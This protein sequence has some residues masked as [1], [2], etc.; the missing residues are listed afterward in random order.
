MVGVQE[1]NG[2][3]EGGEFNWKSFRFKLELVFV[4]GAV[5]NTM[6]PSHHDISSG[7]RFDF[8][9]GPQPLGSRKSFAGPQ[10]TN[11]YGSGNELLGSRKSMDWAQAANGWCPGMQCMVSRRP[12]VCAQ[13]ING[14]GPGSQ[15]LGPK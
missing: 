2:R 12:L 15:W 9:H 7:T 10:E 1:I 6:E 5:G 14:W 11:G 4:S 8:L 13:E 3:V